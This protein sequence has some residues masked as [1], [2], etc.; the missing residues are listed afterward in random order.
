MG[1]ILDAVGGAIDVAV[2]LLAMLCVAVVTYWGTTKILERL[3][4]WWGHRPLSI[5]RPDTVQ[6]SRHILVDGTTSLTC[7]KCGKVTILDQKRVTIHKIARKPTIEYPFGYENEAI[8]CGRCGLMFLA[9]PDTDFDPIKAGKPYDFHT[10]HTF[11]K[12]ENW[13]EMRAKA[14]FLQRPPREQDWVQ[15]NGPVTKESGEVIDMQLGE[16]VYRKT[17]PDGRII[18]EIFGLP[19]SPILHVTC[20]IQHVRTM[21]FAT[22]KVG[23]PV[24]I[25]DADGYRKGRVLS[26]GPDSVRVADAA[27]VEHVNIERLLPDVATLADVDNNPAQ[28]PTEPLLRTIG[29]NP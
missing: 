26:I 1:P 20:D 18:V 3:K 5:Q 11:V 7:P 15:I 19:G 29:S 21:A 17:L 13:E 27:G 4:R 2:L 16:G 28:A 22:F 14:S 12:P 24:R 10:Y 23:D 6:V 25:V 8:G 9:T